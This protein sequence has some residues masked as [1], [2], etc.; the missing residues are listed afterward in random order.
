MAR[1]EQEIYDSL[2]AEKEATPEFASLTSNSLTAM[3][4]L[5]LWL[6]AKAHHWHEKIFDALKAEIDAKAAAAIPNTVAWYIRICKEF[7]Y[8]DPLIFVNNA[9]SYAVIDETKKIVSQVAVVE[10]ALFTDPELLIKLAKGSAGNLQPLSNAELTAFN[11]YINKRKVAG[12]QITTLSLN[13]DLLKLTGNFYY[14]ALFKLEDVKAD[15]DAKGNELLVNLAYNGYLY[16]SKLE[17]KIQQTLGYFDHDLTSIEAT[18]ASV[19]NWAAIGRRYNPLAGYITFD[20]PLSEMLTFIP[21]TD[22]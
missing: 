6:V 18:P 8:G 2:I 22:V 15:L 11:A 19:I 16:A 5:W 4:R 17:D 7:Q 14:N 1:S 9:P 20:Q 12:A 10:R 13:A 21:Q 3:W